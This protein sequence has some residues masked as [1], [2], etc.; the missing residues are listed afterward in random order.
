MNMN[1]MRAIFR[2]SLVASYVTRYRENRFERDFG[3]E[4]NEKRASI[5]QRCI[6]PPPPSWSHLTFSAI[7]QRAAWVITGKREIRGGN[8]CYEFSTVSTR[9]YKYIPGWMQMI[10]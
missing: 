9:K 4:W 1:A 10:N 7:D 2:S 6:Q 8:R 3:Y 5:I